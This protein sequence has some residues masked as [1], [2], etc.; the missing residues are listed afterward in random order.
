M[1]HIVVIAGFTFYC[2]LVWLIPKALMVVSGIFVGIFLLFLIYAFL[3]D[4]V[5]KSSGDW[6]SRDVDSRD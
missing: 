2:V 6:Q 3:S 1:K 4:G 5:S